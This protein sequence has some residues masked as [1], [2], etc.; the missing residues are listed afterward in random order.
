MDCVKFEEM[1]SDYV[2]G[3]LAQTAQGPFAE[4]ALCCRACRALLDDVKSALGECKQAFEVDTP[5]ELDLVLEMIPEECAP[6]DC[7][8]F[9]ELITEFLDGFVPASTYHRFEEHEARCATCSKLLTGV[10]YAVAACHSVHTYEE[11]EIPEGVTSRLLAIMPERRPSLLAALAEQAR[12]MTG[13][14]MP[15][16]SG[17]IRWSF[18]TASGLAFA[19]FAVLLLGFSD[20]RTIAGIYRQAH[21]KAAEIYSQGADIYAQKDE[22]VAGLHKVGSGLGEIWDTIGGQGESNAPADNRERDQNPNSTENN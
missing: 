8:G 16:A 14:L 19:T 11:Y 3:L 22:V 12:A 9:E 6:L 18:A 5:F 21:V 10:V 2:D 20:D 1:L 15:R 4:H 7:A 13:H 17:G